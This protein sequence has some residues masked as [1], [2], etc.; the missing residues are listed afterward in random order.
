MEGKGF[1]PRGVN[2]PRLM[3][4]YKLRNCDISRIGRS[5]RRQVQGLTNVAD[6]VVPALVLVEERST[7]GK[8]EKREP[9][10]QGQ[11][12]ARRNSDENV[13]H[14]T[15]ASFRLHFTVRLLTHELRFP[16]LSGN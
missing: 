11:R 2:V 12:P 3:P 8:I 1:G 4:G 7:R 13:S 10:Q 6:R 16:L 5:Q 15:H 14:K 9:G